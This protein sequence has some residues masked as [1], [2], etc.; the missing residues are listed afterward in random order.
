MPR[1]D[2]RHGGGPQHVSD[3]TEFAPLLLPAVT[4]VLGGEQM[5]VLGARDDLPRV[6]RVEGD[7]P[8]TG[9][10]LL[11]QRQHLPTERGIMGDQDLAGGARRAVGDDFD[12]GSSFCCTNLSNCSWV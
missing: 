5:A 9:I 6:R 11:R 3:L 8:H 2:L 10:G 1:L 7:S 4:A 12:F